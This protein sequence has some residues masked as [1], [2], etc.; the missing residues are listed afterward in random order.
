MPISHKT[1]TGNRGN[2]R[3]W[4]DNVCGDFV[5]G[6]FYRESLQREQAGHRWR[7]KEPESE[8]EPGLNILTELVWG[9]AEQF[10]QN[11]RNVS[12]DLSSWKIELYGD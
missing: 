6:N 1:S 7:Q 8:E 2:L 12:L 5:Y 11:L 4:R 3:V 10:S 9:Q